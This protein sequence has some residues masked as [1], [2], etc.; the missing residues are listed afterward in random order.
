MVNRQVP[1]FLERSRRTVTLIGTQQATDDFFNFIL[2][3]PTNV[4]QEDDSD[5]N[6]PASELVGPLIEVD[7]KNDEV[8][9]TWDE[10]TLPAVYW[11]LF[12]SQAQNPRDGT[13]FKIT[14]NSSTEGQC[15][16]AKRGASFPTYR[17]NAF[18]A[19]HQEIGR[20][21]RFEDG[22]IE[23]EWVWRA[24]LFLP[25]SGLFNAAIRGYTT[26]LDTKLGLG[27]AQQALVGTEHIAIQQYQ[28]QRDA[29][30]TFTQR[31][32]H[33]EITL[34]DI[35]V[36]NNISRVHLPELS[37]DSIDVQYLESQERMVDFMRRDP[38]GKVVVLFTFNH[39]VAHTY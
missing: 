11:W 37:E 1:E 17:V 25:E 3:A 9:L 5:Q 10:V 2:E 15:W 33:R 28:R 34:Q 4:S 36:F 16:L 32:K 21:I 23:Y 29:R 26:S 35:A 13:W 24:R 18:S 27:N 38:R 20:W 7:D 14:G 22:G 6:T 12:G 31:Q 19:A 8:V 30:F 39:A